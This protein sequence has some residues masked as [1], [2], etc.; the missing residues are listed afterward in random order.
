MIIVTSE[1]MMDTVIDNIRSNNYEGFQ[2]KGIALL[3]ADRIGETVSDVSVVASQDNVEEYVCREWVDEVF[4]NL[5]K[6]IPLPKDMMNHFIEMGVTVHL[7]LIE[8]SKLEGEVQRVERLGSYTVLTSSINMATWKEVFYKRAMDIA[9]LLYTSR[10]PV[11]C[12][13]ASP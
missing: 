5:P 10:N 6:E 9:C 7:K 8:M 4:I 13:E 3:D 12:S 11:G 1:G 2:F